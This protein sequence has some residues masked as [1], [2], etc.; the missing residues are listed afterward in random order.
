MYRALLIACAS[1]L[2]DFA[3]TPLLRRGT[4]LPY[5]DMYLRSLFVSL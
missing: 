1:I 4:I 3:H 2:C 5:D